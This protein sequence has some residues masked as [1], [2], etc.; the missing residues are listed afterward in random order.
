VPT[1]GSDRF[2][3]RSDRVKLLNRNSA[4]TAM[5]KVDIMHPSISVEISSVTTVWQEPTVS[6]RVVNDQLWCG[7]RHEEV[8][9]VGSAGLEPKASCV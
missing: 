8:K 4:W 2:L 6:N 3:A 7:C 9:V 5:V 1:V